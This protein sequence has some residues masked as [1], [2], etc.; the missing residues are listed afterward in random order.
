[1]VSWLVPN[2]K[3]G[4]FG[5]QRV[6]LLFIVGEQADPDQAIKHCLQSPKGGAGYGAYLSQTLGRPLQE[7]ED[8][9]LYGRVNHQCRYRPKCERRRA[10]RRWERDGRL[11]R[12]SAHTCLQT[13]L[14]G[15]V[16]LTRCASF[17]LQ[18]GAI[19]KTC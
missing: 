10:F 4:A 15:K 1:M 13:I 17:L 9:V 14:T 11:V 16:S 19:T 12:V 18:S 5:R 7:I 6:N 2:Q 8:T 3:G